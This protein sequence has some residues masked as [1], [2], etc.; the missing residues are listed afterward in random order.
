MILGVMQPYFFP[1]IGYFQLIAASDLFVV[2]DDVQYIK[3]G[4]INRNRMLVNGQPRWFTLPVAQG[5]ATARINQRRFAHDFAAE[6]TRVLR[7]LT[8]AYRKAPQFE[9]TIELVRSCFVLA[10]QNVSE[11]VT[12]ALETT[13]QYLGITTP[14][15]K[16]SEISKND[17]MAAE[18]RVLEIVRATGAD[19]YINPSG[20]T[21]LYDRSRF[22]ALGVQ[23]EFLFSLPVPYP[24]LANEFVPWLS[25]IDVLVNNSPEQVAALLTAYELR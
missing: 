4:W 3:G 14:I 8:A 12:S 25:I 5:P 21:D 24:Q 19:R 23:L 17:K 22:S 10:D 11:F 7:E 9:R 18:D 2:H 6:K 16:S 20:G 1:Y 13:C 15:R